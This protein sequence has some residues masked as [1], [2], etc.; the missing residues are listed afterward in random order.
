MEKYD[1]KVSNKLNDILLVCKYINIEEYFWDMFI[2]DA[3]IGNTD[4]NTGNWGL[5]YN[6]KLDKILSVPFIF[7]C[8]NSF[9]PNMNDYI[10]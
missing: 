2:I 1:Y 5:F 4:R 6:E 9:Y 8:E 3:F 7:D 10:L